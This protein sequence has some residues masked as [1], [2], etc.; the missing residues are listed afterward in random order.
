MLHGKKSQFKYFQK[1]PPGIVIYRFP[2]EVH[3]HSIYYNLVGL[4]SL[5]HQN[6]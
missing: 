6:V 3:H 5:N 1:S 4:N 2:L